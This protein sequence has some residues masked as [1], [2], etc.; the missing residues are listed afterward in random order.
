MV[1]NPSADSYESSEHILFTRSQPINPIMRSNE[2][3]A[4]NPWLVILSHVRNHYIIW[5]HNRDVIKSL[6]NHNQPV[7]R[8]C[9]V[10][11]KLWVKWRHSVNTQHTL[12][13]ISISHLK[14]A[15]LSHNLWQVRRFGSTH[16]AE[17][18]LTLVG[19]VGCP[20]GLAGFLVEMEN[21]NI[22]AR[23]TGI[24][25]RKMIEDQIRE[26]A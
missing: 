22:H 10:L 21:L 4:W 13:L 11:W 8:K 12:W 16:E 25:W 5:R 24:A 23:V 20:G 9:A 18:S 15:L 2:S 7:T 6:T 26:D 17:E 14:S 1:R 3:H 19:F